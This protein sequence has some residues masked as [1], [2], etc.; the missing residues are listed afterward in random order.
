MHLPWGFGPERFGMNDA[1]PTASKT[2]NDP[3]AGGN[4]V[5]RPTGVPN[6]PLGLIPVTD[7]LSGHVVSP[8]DLP[9]IGCGVGGGGDIGCVGGA[10]GPAADWEPASQAQQIGVRS[11][12]NWESAAAG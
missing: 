5:E 2:P 4:T 1:L 11:H 7:I 8:A 9:P 3:A 12:G 10:G 6:L